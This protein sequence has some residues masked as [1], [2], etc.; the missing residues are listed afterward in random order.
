MTSRGIRHPATV[1][2]S[3]EMASGSSSSEA[4]GNR[5]AGRGE[6]QGLTPAEIEEMAREI[7]ARG[8]GTIT[9]FFLEAHRPLRAL[10]AQTL[11]AFGPLT[12]AL[13]G[14]GKAEKLL[15]IMNSDSSLELLVRQLE[16]FS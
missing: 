13:F 1:D 15:G 2:P 11:I 7:S 4:F 14:S 6:E 12:A 5:A 8:L 9:L 10:A 3:R 16:E